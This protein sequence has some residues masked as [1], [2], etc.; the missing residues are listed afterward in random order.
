MLVVLKLHTLQHITMENK[1]FN[2]T[3]ISGFSAATSAASQ[4]CPP[5]KIS[6]QFPDVFQLQKQHIS[7][8]LSMFLP[9]VGLFSFPFFV[10]EPK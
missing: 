6:R 4:F 9:H 1:V 2:G 7:Q 10:A 5:F 8:F 3:Q